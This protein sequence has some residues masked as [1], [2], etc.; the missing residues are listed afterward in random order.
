MLIDLIGAIA[1]HALQVADSS[2]GGLLYLYAGGMP[3]GLGP[4]GLAAGAAAAAAGAGAAA[5]GPHLPSVSAAHR[6]MGYHRY[7]D[8]AGNPYWPGISAIPADGIVYPQASD[9]DRIRAG[10]RGGFSPER[11]G[12]FSPNPLPVGPRGLPIYPPP[13]DL[14]RPIAAQT[15]GGRG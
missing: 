9:M 4:G 10:H 11:D 15:T 6:A 8:S 5:Y 1:L 12:Q 13:P 3:D 2:W 14:G 7:R